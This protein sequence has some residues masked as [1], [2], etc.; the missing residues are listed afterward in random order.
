MRNRIFQIRRKFIIL[1]IKRLVILPLGNNSFS[2]RLI[3]IIFIILRVFIL[4]SQRIIFP[5]CNNFCLIL[6]DLVLINLRDADHW[7]LSFIFGLIPVR[8]LLLTTR[9]V[10]LDTYFLFINHFLALLFTFVFLCH[11]IAL[12]GLFLALVEIWILFSVLLISFAMSVRVFRLLISLIISPAFNLRSDIKH[13]FDQ[14][15]QN[16]VFVFSF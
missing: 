1:F 15:L 6:N 7:F 14:E 11:E 3:H 4:L 9:F 12:T 16:F 13:L 8:I 2:K 10:H 5:W